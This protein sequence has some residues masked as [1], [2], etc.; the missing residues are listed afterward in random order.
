MKKTIALA[1]LGLT[2]SG[3][4]PLVKDS[5]IPRLT[6]VFQVRQVNAAVTPV[7]AATFDDSPVPLMLILSRETGVAVLVQP[8]MELENRTIWAAPANQTFTMEQGI[9]VETRGVDDGVHASDL[10]NMLV[11]MRRNGATRRSM[12]YLTGN[13]QIVRI[14][15]D[16]VYSNL[17]SE[18]LSGFDRTISTYVVQEDCKNA[19]IQ[20]SNYYWI[21][22]RDVV[23][24]S[25]QRLGLNGGA[26][27]T[28][29][30]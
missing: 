25:V 10:G 1:L 24:Q 18:V 2:V 21:D 3:C 27:E 12:E 15:F 29:L 20:F 4:G 5:I 16:C 17:G 30:P 19:Q 6:S 23:R 9:I 8:F 14:D 13:D 22:D 11:E 26:V 7:S 28:L